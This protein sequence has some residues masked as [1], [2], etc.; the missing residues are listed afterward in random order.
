MKPLFE[1]LG[2]ALKTHHLHTPA[3][4]MC[5]GVA[6]MAQQATLVD[7]FE[8]FI[9]RLK[10][11]PDRINHVDQLAFLQGVELYQE[12]DMHK[13]HIFDAK[14]NVFHDRALRAADIVQS[15][16][17]E[18][19]GGLHLLM[20]ETGLYDT[21]GLSSVLHTLKTYLQ[22]F[23]QPCSFILQSHAHAIQ[24]GYHKGLWRIVN[25]VSLPNIVESRDIHE[26]VAGIQDAFCTGKA[27]FMSLEWYC[28]GH[29]ARSLARMSRR[30][31]ADEGWK[32]AHRV[33]PER[34][35]EFDY[36]GASW[37]YTACQF[38]DEACVAALVKNTPPINHRG[39]VHESTPLGIACQN[40]F[41][42]IVR[43]LLEHGAEVDKH[44]GPE[45]VT[46]LFI[47]VYYGHHEVASILVE[48]GADVSFTDK[49]SGATI[50]DYARAANDKAMMDILQCDGRAKKRRRVS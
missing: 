24:I 36:M 32:T 34:A 46:P 25:I 9:S 6:A 7:D 49:D 47:A 35:A 18:A 28:C 22:N 30:L 5:F 19:R 41:A 38:N 15:V 45:D 3:D 43:H 26:I 37:L 29:D 8:S 40:G 21:N 17:L 4:G 14:A 11:W 1:R 12:P 10:K 2:K 39:G 33:T 13:P 31:Q 16:S 23:Q 50:M 42:N 27:I 48:Y 20:A 44:S